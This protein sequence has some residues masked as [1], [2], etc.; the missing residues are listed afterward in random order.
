MLMEPLV[1][2][3][4]GDIVYVKRKDCGGESIPL[5]NRTYV[6]NEEYG[7]WAKISKINLSGWFHYVKPISDT[8]P[9]KIRKA[10]KSKIYQAPENNN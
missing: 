6:T 5:P 3:S 1:N 9:A 7:Y 4:V 10:S 2:P 8:V